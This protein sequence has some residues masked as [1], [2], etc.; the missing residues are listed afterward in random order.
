M[1]L[2]RWALSP[3]P[4]RQPFGHERRRRIGSS[5]SVRLLA[6]QG[7]ESLWLQTA[8]GS[9]KLGDSMLGESIRAWRYS[10]AFYTPPFQ[11]MFTR[12][13]RQTQI[14][15]LMHGGAAAAGRHQFTDMV[16]AGAV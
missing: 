1:A 7:Q 2:P 13:G 9:G 10:D 14:E 8:A 16:P 12:S 3:L 5:T 6:E 11:H 4:H 15:G